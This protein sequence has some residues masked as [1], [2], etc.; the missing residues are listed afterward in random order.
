MTPSERKIRGQIE[1]EISTLEKSI[2][3]LTELIESEAQSDV[4]DWFSTK[5]SNTSGR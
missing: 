4:N 1:R 2:I 3:T 5:E